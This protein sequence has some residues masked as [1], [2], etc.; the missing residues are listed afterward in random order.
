MGLDRYIITVEDVHDGTE[1]TLSASP[2]GVWWGEV[3]GPEVLEVIHAV[4]DEV[5][6]AL[7]EFGGRHEQF[8][9]GLNQ[10]QLELARDGLE[11]VIVRVGYMAE[12]RRAM[13][14]SETHRLEAAWRRKIASTH[15]EGVDRE[16]Q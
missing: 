2:S 10:R 4:L 15:E 12:E 7:C 8:A 5:H 13:E 1:H 16:D 9:S 11:D 6:F 14:S 3:S